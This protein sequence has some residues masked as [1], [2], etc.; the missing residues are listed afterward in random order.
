MTFIGEKK[1]LIY[2]TNNFKKILKN[3]HAER[4]LKFISTSLFKNSHYSS[5]SPSNSESGIP[6]KVVNGKGS[7]TWFE[8]E[9]FPH[10][11]QISQSWTSIF[12]NKKVKI[13]PH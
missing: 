4:R 1:S 10:G 5:S 2:L 9:D 12:T 3:L 7:T 11:L 13:H 8:N 6:V